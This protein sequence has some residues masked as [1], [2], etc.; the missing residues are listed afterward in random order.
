MLIAIILAVATI[1]IAVIGLAWLGRTIFLQKIKKNK[2]SI[3]LII[4][5]HKHLVDYGRSN[6]R[7]NAAF[8]RL[9]AKSSAIES[10]IGHDNFVS[11]IHIGSYILTNSY[12]LPFGIHEMRRHYNSEFRW[13]NA[14]G[15][16]ADS[17]QTVL[18]RHAGRREDYV[19]ILQKKS[20]RFWN[21][22]AQGWTAIAALPISVLQAFGIISES[23]AGKAR[24]SWLFRLWNF[25]LALVTLAGPI[26]AYLAD[27]EKINAAMRMMVQ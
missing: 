27:S 22:V 3:D 8:I 17:I 11:G 5:F 9:A 20:S 6:G 14:G 19:D 18:F 21:C 15:S 25:L 4:D 13:D 26:I 10:I 7:D 16:I 12:L 2:Q 24:Q 23:R 1:A